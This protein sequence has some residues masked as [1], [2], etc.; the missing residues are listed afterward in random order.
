LQR[1]WLL[2]VWLTTAVQCAINVVLATKRNGRILVATH[3]WS[4][5]S[6]PALSLLLWDSF[7]N[8]D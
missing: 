2:H 4:R 7:C 8:A 6:C 5:W 3:D 1:L